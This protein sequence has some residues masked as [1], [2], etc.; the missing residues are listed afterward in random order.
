MD[1]DRLVLVG[2]QVVV[3]V[4]LAVLVGLGHNSA[5]SDA[6]LAISGSIVGTGAYQVLKAK[7]P[8]E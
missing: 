4:T 2:A 7:P 1:K 6:M 3:F 8:A 5:I